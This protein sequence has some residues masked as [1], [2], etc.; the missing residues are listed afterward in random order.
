MNQPGANLPTVPFGMQLS[1]KFRHFPFWGGGGQKLA[2][3]TPQS[4]GKCKAQTS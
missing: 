1:S 4:G 2:D 3:M